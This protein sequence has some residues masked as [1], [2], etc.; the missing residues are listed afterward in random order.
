[1]LI[2]Y[3]SASLALMATFRHLF[4]LVAKETARSRSL[5]IIMEEVGS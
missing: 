5:F 1:M 4:T 2:Q 3:E